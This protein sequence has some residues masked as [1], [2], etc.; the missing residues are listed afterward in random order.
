MGSAEVQK[1]AERLDRWYEADAPPGG[2]MIPAP[3]APEPVVPERPAGVATRVTSAAD[4]F[5]AGEVE[6]APE[7]PI[8]PA[9]PRPALPRAPA[10]TQAPPE[11][12]RPT[13]PAAVSP[14]A[15]LSAPAEPGRLFVS[16]TPW[17]T[18]YLDGRPVGNTPVIDLSIPPGSHSIRIARDGFQSYERIIEVAPGEQVRL[19]GIVLPET[20]R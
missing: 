19:T 15:P 6:A 18:L 14:P 17:G 12:P 11:R 9:A 5:A 3:R 2:M 10:R 20:R 1:L 16:A 13:S 8:Q 7:N 4:S